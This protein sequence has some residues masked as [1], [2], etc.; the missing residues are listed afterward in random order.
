M[1][2]QDSLGGNSH[3]IMIAC[4]SMADSDCAE[5]LA[6]LQYAARARKIRNCPVVVL[7]QTA[8]DIV[9]CAPL[10]PAP[11]HNAGFCN[12]MYR[13]LTCCNTPKC[14]HVSVR[15]IILNISEWTPF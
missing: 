8:P 15:V 10:P 5:T 13:V 2:A 7:H 6:T 1:A 14:S 11:A 4:I 9:Q 12:V 3:T